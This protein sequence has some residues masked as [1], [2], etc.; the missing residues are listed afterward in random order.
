MTQNGTGD[1]SSLPDSL[2][3]PT[4]GEFHSQPDSAL[5][6]IRSPR[7]KVAGTAD[8]G[9]L[10]SSQLEAPP[11]TEITANVPE[12]PA[13]ERSLD[14]GLNNLGNT[15]FMNASLQCILH[16]EVNSCLCIYR[17]SYLTLGCSF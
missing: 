12:R 2:P 4:A 7:S 15:C 6:S 11:T 3:L 5:P 1:S 17:Q 10:Q 16:I 13:A 8:S 9:Q 14:V